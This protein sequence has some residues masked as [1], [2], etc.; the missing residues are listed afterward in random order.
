MLIDVTF[1]IEML[2]FGMVAACGTAGVSWHYGDNSGTSS[3][4]EKEMPTQFPQRNLDIFGSLKAPG[5]YDLGLEG[6]VDPGGASSVWDA[7]GKLHW[8]GSLITQ[9]S[10][11]FDMITNVTPTLTFTRTVSVTTGF[12]YAWRLATGQNYHSV[13]IR[14]RIQ[15][16]GSD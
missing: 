8:D 9:E 12:R 7:M 5:T 14:L 2:G 4:A 6:H 1:G 10:D 16:P 13:Y 15:P 11:N 3:T